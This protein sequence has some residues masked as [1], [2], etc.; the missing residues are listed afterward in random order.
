VHQIHI[1]SLKTTP[2]LRAISN[3]VAGNNSPHTNQTAAALLNNSITLKLRQ[4]WCQTRTPEA[5]T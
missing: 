3:P 1:K 5:T 4:Q 2:H